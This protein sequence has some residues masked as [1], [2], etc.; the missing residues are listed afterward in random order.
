MNDTVVL[1]NLVVVGVVKR[2]KSIMFRAGTIHGLVSPLFFLL[3]FFAAIQM[4]HF[5]GR[6][7]DENFSLDVPVSF[8]VPESLAR[9]HSRQ[10]RS[11]KGARRR[12]SINYESVK[13][14]VSRRRHPSVPMGI[15]KNTVQA[16]DPDFLPIKT[17]RGGRQGRFDTMK[18][19][20]KRKLPIYL[21]DLSDKERYQ[22]SNSSFS[23]LIRYLKRRYHKMQMR[24]IPNDRWAKL[25][26]TTCIPSNRTWEDWD[27]RAPHALI[28]GAQKA[29]SSALANYLYSHSQIVSTRKE[30]HFLSERMDYYNNDF[31]GI[32]QAQARNHYLR[33]IQSAMNKSGIEDLKLHPSMHVIDA[34]PM[35]LP[36]SDRVPQR[37]LCL[38]PWARLIVIL[39]E[40]I[41]RAYSQFNMDVV[42]ADQEMRITGNQKRRVRLGTFDAFI[43]Q[44][45]E[46][47][48]TL[49]VLLPENVTESERHQHYGSKKELEAWKTY[50]KLGTLM[51]IGRSLYAIQL[52]HWIKAY[53]A[54]DQPLR[55]MVIKSEELKE[56]TENTYLKV[57]DFLDLPHE[58]PETFNELHKHRYDHIEPL[59]PSLRLFLEQI[60]EP[61]NSQ[62]GE[63]LGTEWEGVW[64]YSKNKTTASQ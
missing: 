58:L 55:L 11:K 29:G 13:E 12:K 56:D 62:L 2:L 25:D 7:H 61:Y 57:L 52:R 40:P 16:N 5:H 22:S 37:V 46:T 19:Q 43:R 9:S 6:I 26:N 63:L 64:Q 34:T 30:L 1:C 50:T 53:A 17:F 36:K 35:Y 42:H 10:F 27:Y 4:F 21:E 51:P 45:Y 32:D 44:D 41:S 47:L 18:K 15:L 23:P 59:S 54:K 31:P 39:R 20:Y 60:F 8:E 3:F 14:T 24:V 38:C 33:H 48:L 28:L 49:G